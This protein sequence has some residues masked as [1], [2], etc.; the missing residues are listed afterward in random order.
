[1]CPGLPSLSLPLLLA[2]GQLT[3]PGRS[4]YF[5]QDKPFMSML[6]QV[7]VALAF[8]LG[9]HKDISAGSTPSKATS[10]SEE[11]RVR[12]QSPEIR[13]MEDRRTILAVFH[14]TSA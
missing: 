6:S 5:K 14:L 4:H 9:L 13:S 10:G 11:L 3:R 12:D 2:F 1:M 8:E 7:A